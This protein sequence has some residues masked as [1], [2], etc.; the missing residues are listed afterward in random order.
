[1]AATAHYGL[2]RINFYGQQN[3]ASNYLDW[4]A[5]Q[6]EDSSA[7]ARIQVRVCVCVMGDG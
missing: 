6:P 1:M 2:W 4:S 3:Y 7:Y 5:A